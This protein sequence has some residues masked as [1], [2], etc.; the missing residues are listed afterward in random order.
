MLWLIA[1]V[2]RLMFVSSLQHA[3]VVR[4]QLLCRPCCLTCNKVHIAVVF[5]TPRAPVM[6]VTGIGSFKRRGCVIAAVTA[7]LA[8]FV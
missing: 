6:I 5:P 3:L 8:F 2:W 7:N 1:A 4:L